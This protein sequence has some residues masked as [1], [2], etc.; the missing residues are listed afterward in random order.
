MSTSNDIDLFLSELTLKQKEYITEEYALL[1]DTWPILGIIEEHC[2]LTSSRDND[3]VVKSELD[4]VDDDEEKKNDNVDVDVDDDDDC[5]E[6]EWIDCDIALNL[7]EYKDIF[8][9]YCVKPNYALRHRRSALEF[10]VAK[11]KFNMFRDACYLMKNI[12][13]PFKHL[14]CYI[15]YVIRIENLESGMYLLFP[16]HATK[17]EDIYKN[18]WKT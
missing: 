9:G 18:T 1:S 13:L 14:C 3:G 11:G 17:Y 5:N 8:C 16:K 15:L 7:N 2:L 6:S 4:L 12:N 10:D